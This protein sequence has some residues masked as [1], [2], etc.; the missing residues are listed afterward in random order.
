MT[1][2]NLGLGL[3]LPWSSRLSSKSLFL[4]GITLGFS[5]SLSLT[6]L[7]L[8]SRDAW[9]RH[10]RKKAER[11]V[12]EVRAGE[13][14]DGVEGLIGELPCSGEVS[15]GVGGVLMLFV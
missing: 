6:G 7:A 11:L 12:V 14:S 5:L 10:V 4:V 13:V 8:Y 3:G 2:L 1:S 9:K 15:D